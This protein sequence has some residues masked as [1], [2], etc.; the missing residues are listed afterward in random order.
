MNRCER[1]G[2][3]RS[4]GTDSTKILERRPEESILTT[5]GERVGLM[6]RA[7]ADQIDPGA[8]HSP[9]PFP[10]VLALE[11]SS[12]TEDFIYFMDRIQEM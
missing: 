11:S 6:T 4:G 10:T 9:L 2:T 12:I 5:C 7:A 1:T 8:A 3:L